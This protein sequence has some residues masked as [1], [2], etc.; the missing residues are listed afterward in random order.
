MQFITDVTA[1]I[2]EAGFR[3][4]KRL[5]EVLQSF[6]TEKRGS[7]YKVRGSYEEVEDLSHRLL[8]LNHHQLSPDTHGRTRHQ[9]SVR[10]VDVSCVIMKYILKKCPKEIEKIQ[11]DGFII[12]MHPDL[13]T[14]YKTNVKV[15]LTFRPQHASTQ[16]VRVDFV[17]QRF[18][19]FYQ[20][21]ASD[22]QVTTLRVSPQDHKDLRR[23]FPYLY[24]TPRQDENE[25]SVTG[26]FMHIAKL[27]EYLLHN[28]QSP[29]KS[30]MNRG[31]ASSRTMSPAPTRSK[32]PED[33][34]C[35]I[36][37]EPIV[38]AEKTTLRCKHSFCKDCLKRAFDYKPVCPTCGQ[39]YGTLTGTQPDG[40]EMTVTKH[41]SSLPGYKEYGTIIVN[42][43]IPSGT[44]KVSKAF[45][46]IQ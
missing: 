7:C 40:G 8:A 30:P 21:M 26:P 29:S 14:A 6:Y 20:R 17:R 37:M 34:T 15:Q 1:T 36:C 12:E 32:D 33:E 22:L 27:E 28:R 43:Y 38:R 10:S 16:P 35:P 13:S 3:D 18:I 41:N 11:N 45:T 9:H 25:L 4:K 2:D 19:S 44:Q 24:F 31:S 42:Y 23:K 5:T 46:P 39:L